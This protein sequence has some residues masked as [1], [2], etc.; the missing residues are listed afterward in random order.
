VC[1]P[2]APSP[3]PPQAKESHEP[4][5][6][7]LAKLHLRRAELDPCQKLCQGLLKVN[8]NHEEASIMLADIMFRK[9][10]VDVRWGGGAGRGLGGSGPPQA[11]THACARLRPYVRGSSGTATTSCGHSRAVRLLYRAPTASVV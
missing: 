8:E 5:L 7:E 6:L 10:D 3:L 11:C 2:L 1:S 4:S 9:D